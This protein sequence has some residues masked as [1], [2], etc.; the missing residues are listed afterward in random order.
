MIVTGNDCCRGGLGCSCVAVTRATSSGDSLRG[1]A[2]EEQRVMAAGAAAGCSATGAGCDYGEE[3][4]ELATVASGLRQRVGSSKVAAP[5]ADDWLRLR[6]DCDSGKQ[7]K[8]AG[9]LLRRERRG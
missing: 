5:L 6:M 4:R 8:R 1:Y 3:G 7:R 9:R 2:K